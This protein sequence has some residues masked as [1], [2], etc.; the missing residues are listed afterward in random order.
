MCRKWAEPGTD[1]GTGTSVP[2]TSI[3]NSGLGTTSNS[4]GFYA[5]TGTGI[6]NAKD[7]TPEEIA[8]G[9]RKLAVWDRLVRKQTAYLGK[10]IQ[11]TNRLC[12]TYYHMWN[13]NDQQIFFSYLYHHLQCQSH[14]STLSLLKRIRTAQLLNNISYGVE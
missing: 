3:N 12:N 2:Q 11:L 13:I 14:Y 4:T 1:T 9:K 7:P 10:S 5:D 8:Y 6:I